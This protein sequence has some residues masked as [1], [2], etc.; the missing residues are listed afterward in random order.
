MCILPNLFAP[1]AGHFEY[2]VPVDDQNTLHV[3]WN[4]D[5]VPVEQRPYVQARIPYWTAPIKDETGR[6]ITSHVVNQ[7]TVA[8]VGQGVVTERERNTW[9][10]ATAG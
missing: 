2:K 6:W 3:V 10:R 9:G 4:W 1:G 7:D 5:A 8:W